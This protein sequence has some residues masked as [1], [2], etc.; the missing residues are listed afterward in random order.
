M[1]SMFH[2]RLFR[3]DLFHYQFYEAGLKD[4][5]YLPTICGLDVHSLQPG[6]W[7]K[8]GDPRGQVH[9]EQACMACRNALV[10]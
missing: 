3:D 5:R 6:A 1:P 8:V 4:Q 2:V 10:V 9:Y 7:F